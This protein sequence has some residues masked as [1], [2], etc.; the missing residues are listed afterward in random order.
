MTTGGK[1][2]SRVK[3]NA[4]LGIN[5]VERENPGNVEDLKREREGSMSSSSSSRSSS[6]SSST[7]SSTDNSI[8]S[9]EPTAAARAVAA[10]ATPRE[11]PHQ[12][13]RHQQQQF[14]QQHQ[15]Q[16]QHQQRQH[17]QQQQGEVHACLLVV[18]CF[19]EIGGDNIDD[20]EANVLSLAIAV[21]PQDKMHAAPRFFL[22][23][24]GKPVAGAGLY[25]DHRCIEEI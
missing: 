13:Q 1:T 7:S 16:H 22:Q 6:E 17:Q 10:L 8:V 18:V 11:Q 24:L 25:T 14:Q 19:G 20:L 21:E 12:T 4:R 5:I 9:A 15:H 2:N 23:M 3:I